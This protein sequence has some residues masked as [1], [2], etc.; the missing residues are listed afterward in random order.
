MDAEHRKGQAMNRQAKK[1]QAK[2]KKCEV[3]FSGFLGTFFVKST[4]GETYTVR[5]VRSGFCCACEWAGFHDTRK[6][7]CSHVEA[8]RDF[9]EKTG[10]RSLSLWPD[11][12]SAR[13]QHRPV[14]QVG[15][16]L[17]ATSRKVKAAGLVKSVRYVAVSCDNESERGV[18]WVQRRETLP[19]QIPQDGDRALGGILKVSGVFDNVRDELNARGVWLPVYVRRANDWVEG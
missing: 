10:S 13:R 3:R 8:V 1:I 15:S 5:E 19:G 9:L 4:S 18:W 16:G 2:A 12:G 17:W 14:R 7:P 11:T 6:N